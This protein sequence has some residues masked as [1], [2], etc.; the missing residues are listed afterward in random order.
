MLGRSGSVK[1]VQEAV[2]LGVDE[3]LGSAGLGLA[4]VGLLQRIAFDY[5]KSIMCKGKTRARLTYH[6]QSEGL[7]GE[8]GAV[9]LLEL[10]GDASIAVASDHGAVAQL[11]GGARGRSA[12]A[13]L[14]GV[15]VSG[16]R[17]TELVHEV[18]DHAVEVQAVVETSVGKVD[19]VVCGSVE[20]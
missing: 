2:V 12:S 13:R 6:G 7:V 4:G 10:I 14:V 20:N 16:V 1:E 19:E 8:L 3:E 11:V 9:C 18:L 15:G 5:M 17:A